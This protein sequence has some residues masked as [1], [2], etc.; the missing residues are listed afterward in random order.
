MYHKPLLFQSASLLASGSSC[1]VW[2]KENEVLVCNFFGRFIFKNVLYGSLAPSATTWR[3]WTSI[4]RCG[5]VPRY[6]CWRSCYWAIP[7]LPGTAGVEDCC[8]LRA[9]VDVV[10]WELCVLNLLRSSPSTSCSTGFEII[11]WITPGNETGGEFP[12][13]SGLK[14]LNNLST[15]PFTILS[16]MF[17]HHIKMCSGGKDLIAGDWK[18]AI[19]IIRGI[20]CEWEFVS[21]IH[22]WNSTYL[23]TR[24]LQFL[25]M[26]IRHFC[27][28]EYNNFC[29]WELEIVQWEINIFAVANDNFIRFAKDNGFYVFR[30]LSASAPHTFFSFF[31]PTRA[32]CTVISCQN[33]RVKLH[34]Q[35]LRRW[36]KSA[37]YIFLNRSFI[38]KIYVFPIYFLIK[39]SHDTCQSNLRVLWRRAWTYVI[40]PG[41]ED[42]K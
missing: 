33:D 24:I 25:R 13:A 21:R 2:S 36:W 31:L 28:R 15:T 41:N 27:E 23:R 40:W 20:F 37:M 32:P 10:C 14:R 39:I 17:N 38:A 18:R 3:P 4:W 16:S 22:W 12:W 5:V 35:K 26:K 11:L 7:E 30:I 42:M 34:S 9:T 29:E 19:R 6:R 1:Y 8:G